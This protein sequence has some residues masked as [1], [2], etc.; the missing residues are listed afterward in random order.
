MKD[1]GGQ[2][3]QVFTSSYGRKGC[4]VPAATPTRAIRHHLGNVHVGTPVSVVRA[5]IAMEVSKQVRKGAEGWTP[6][7]CRAAERFAEW[8]HLENRA[9][10][11]MVMGASL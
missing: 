7:M 6:E 4:R 1:Y 10:Y 3:V 8:Q 5:E 11:A 2:K 9:E